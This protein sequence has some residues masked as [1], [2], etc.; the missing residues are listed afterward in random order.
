MGLT[1]K[2]RE[3]IRFLEHNGY[4]FIRARGGSHYIYSNGIHSIPIPIHDG[5]DLTEKLIRLILR[6]ANISKR[7]LMEYLGR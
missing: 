3:L 7:S 4:A 5:R 6:E 1:M 2:P